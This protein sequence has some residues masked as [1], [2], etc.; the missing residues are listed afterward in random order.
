MSTGIWQGWIIYVFLGVGVFCVIYL[1]K[2]W[3]S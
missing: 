3:N 2:E 1:I